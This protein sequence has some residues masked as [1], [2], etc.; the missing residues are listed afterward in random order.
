[1]MHSSPM[2]L[3]VALDMAKRLH[4]ELAKHMTAEQ[5]RDFTRVEHLIHEA[6]QAHKKQLM[7]A[8]HESPAKSEAPAAEPV[9]ARK[10]FWG[11]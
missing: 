10:G 3:T 1:M 9:Q 8:S 4:H 5:K 6:Q 2:P 11:R 7:R